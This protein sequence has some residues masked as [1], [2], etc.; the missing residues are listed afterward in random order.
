MSP[1]KAQDVKTTNKIFEQE[2]VASRNFEALDRVYTAAARVLPPGAPMITGRENIKTFWRNVIE[3]M[4]V[5][6]GKLETVDFRELGD[7]AVEIGKAALN[8]GTPG[9]PVMEVKYVVV[10]KQEDGAWKWDIDIWNA[11]A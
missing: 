1:E 2:V 6:S 7:T 11:S 8:F 9:A 10:W 3:G 4:N 5:V